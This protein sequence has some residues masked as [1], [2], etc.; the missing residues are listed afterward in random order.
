MLWF[1]ACQVF[2][3]ISKVI[4]KS[5]PYDVE[6]NVLFAEELW[7]EHCLKYR[8][9]VQKA[10]FSCFSNSCRKEENNSFFSGL[11]C[12]FPSRSRVEDIFAMLSVCVY[13]VIRRYQIFCNLEGKL[14][15]VEWSGFSVRIQF[16]HF[17]D[18]I[19]VT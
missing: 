18:R 11:V 16:V 14:F 8:R 6:V 2:T 3:Y 15:L 10:Q 19:T 13:Y 5:F 12:Y 1:G 9:A 4:M 17:W 7:P